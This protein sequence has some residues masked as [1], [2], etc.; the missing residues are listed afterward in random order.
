MFGGRAF[1][2]T[3]MGTKC[4][5]LLADLSLYLF[6]AGFIQ[7]RPKKNEKRLGRSFYFTFSYIDDVLSINNS[8]VGDLVDRIYPIEL[9]I[10]DTICTDTD[11]SASYLDLHLE[12]DSEERLENG[13]TKE[14]IS[15]FPL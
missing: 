2:Q 11:R 14:M 8:R 9:A 10:K 12:I 15:I 7:G 5:A 13:T 1:Q 3:V 4:A 6:E